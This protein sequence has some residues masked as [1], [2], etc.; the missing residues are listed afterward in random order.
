MKTIP[1]FLPLPTEPRRRDLLR[2]T[3]R[4]LALAVIL[5]G[6][7]VLI[8]WALDIATL[9]SVLP[10]VVT[11]KANTAVGLIL[12]GAALALLGMA[13]V[14][15]GARRLSQACAGGAFLLGLLSLAEYLYHWNL[16]I[17]QLLFIE[18]AGTVG[19]MAPGRMAP[20]TAM[21][22]M[23]LGSA[24]ILMGFRRSVFAAQLLALLAGL[25]GSLTA[26]GYF[27][28]VTALIGL[29]PYTQMAIH[30]ALA[31]IILSAGLLFTHFD[32]DLMAVVTRGG[33]L[34][35]S[36]LDSPTAQGPGKRTFEI[37]LLAF[38]AALVVVITV[39]GFLYFESR[40]AE[41][42]QR[43]SQELATIADLKTG[44]I[45]GW[46]EERVAD[47]RMAMQTPLFARNAAAFFADPTSE[48]RRTA[49]LEWFG[50]LRRNSGYEEIALFDAQGNARLTLP[51]TSDPTDPQ[52]GALL[53]VVPQA[54]DVLISDLHRGR[55]GEVHIDLIVPLR[56]TT[57]PSVGGPA[58][59]V[60]T[61]PATI[62]AVVLRID[63]RRFLYP[64]V[65][66]W[67]TPSK[68]AETLLVR[69]EGDE[70]VFLNELRHRP[71]TAL[72]LRR[73]INDPLLPAAMAARG[74]S[75]EREGIDYRGVKV[76]ALT[77][78]I[79]D[80]PWFI[81]A[82]VD[83]EE[84][85]APLRSQ[86][87]T[88]GLAISVL[89]VAVALGL[90]LFWRRSTV[91]NL[92]R[93]LV[94]EREIGRLSR[95]YAAL[96]Q[97]NQAVVRA[98]T[99]EELLSTVCK[100][101]AEFGQLR[102]VCIG[103]HDAAQRMVKP[104]AWA[105]EDQGFLTGLAV[106]TDE[107][108]EGRGPS[109]TAV[110]EERSVVVNDFA[111]DPRVA[112][113]RQR[114]AVYKFMSGGAFPIRV[115]GRVWG[116][117]TVFAPEAGYFRGKEIALFEEAA[118]DISFA[119]DRL[120][121]RAEH[122]QTVEF[123]KRERALFSALIITIPDHIYF[124][125][126]NSRFVRINDIMVRRFGL[127]N[128]DEAVGRT[129]AD[130]F[131]AEHARQAHEDEQRVMNTGTAII[132]LEEKET[133]PDGRVTWVST[134]KVPLRD[135][136]GNITGLVGIS[137]DITASR[138][139]GE[140]LRRSEER[141]HGAIAAA[142]L[143]PY[144]ID[145]DAKR[146]TFVG[147]DIFRLTGYPAEEI[148]PAILKEIVQESIV[149]GNSQNDITT[150]EAQRRFRS[151]EID[152]WDLDIRIRTRNGEDRWLHDV[153]VP[154]WDEHG[155]VTSAIGIFQDLTERKR[156]EE[157][158]R[159]NEQQ[160]R[161]LNLLQATL[162]PPNP[163]EQKLKLITEAVVRIVGADF[164]RIW[165]IRSGD[166]CE[167][168]CVHAQV[169]EGPHRCRLR[170]RC[171][172]LLASSGRYTHTDGRDHGRVPFGCYKIGK[173]AAGEVPSF[174]TNEVTIDPRVHNHA[175][176]GE[177]GLVA[178][179]GYRLADV[180]GTP[181]GVL[182][183]FSKHPISAQDNSLLEG[184][185]HASSLVLHSALA[186]AKITEQLDELRRWHD[187][188]LGR[189]DRVVEVK[190]EV[191]QLLARLGEPSRYPSAEERPEQRTEANAQ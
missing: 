77:R 45:A 178:F 155:R 7:S 93:E 55:T 159:S 37:G 153:S 22:F 74:A 56:D 10:G 9:K 15:P 175:W 158:L 136:K 128:S 79:P 141:Y 72:V 127:R 84:I 62:G 81:V 168:G 101:M 6:G 61:P 69:R 174:L 31:F 111:A 52:L 88:V 92:Q 132:G 21:N 161:E 185:A 19:T 57:A 146:F 89:L 97:V 49:I 54:D 35:G 137:R 39:L 104:V 109:G 183:L 38:A 163:L 186:E 100:A 103:E 13:P 138:Q 133:W 188:L 24:V 173:I 32:A 59:E 134:T 105:G 50:A 98:D 46:R 64:L 42:Q 16:H 126:R 171:L 75:G 107:R 167:A 12:T 139:A 180:D 86:A 91:A 106:Y 184:I 181:L 129:E 144:V 66:S 3:S 170:D 190:N 119:L 151:G 47:A 176:A 143:V 179:A 73:P 150:D 20:L 65:Q 87:W 99:R 191:N 44:Q 115:R 70:V 33:D 58:G 29:T 164:A 23:L 110:R 34:R 41:I 145:Y 149:T 1:P 117:L 142:G 160:L 26:V 166:R 162:L 68:T 112:P 96:S 154:L 36:G 48:A 78:P 108:A 90:G 124:K 82:K 157:A 118:S 43:I 17:D 95:L 140:E 30:T 4:W 11:M 60:Q 121:D 123:L 189:E 2:A 85:Y 67:P 51:L 28:G 76:L 14:R 182:A 177:L 94:A 116:C 148:T 18:P 122:L 53:K 27:S 131:T 40:R 125:D 114:L 63:P 25:I 113:W 135:E 71:D 169:A 152:H 8:G 147:N 156:A 187:A 5:V 120:E 80:S 172:H 102:L 130:F 83:Q 165:M